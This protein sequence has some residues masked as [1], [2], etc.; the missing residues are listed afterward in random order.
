MGRTFSDA[1]ID[2]IIAGSKIGRSGRG[3]RSLNAARE[4]LTGR[5]E[6]IAA[7]ARAQEASPQSARVTVLA[8]LERGERDEA[9]RDLVRALVPPQHRQAL[10][11]WLARRGGELVDREASG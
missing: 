7:A 3:Q 2:A 8:I 10:R 9:G 6:T 11:R 5:S 1:E 4:Y